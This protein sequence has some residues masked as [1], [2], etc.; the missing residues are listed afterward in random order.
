MRNLA[1]SQ[2]GTVTIV[3]A[4]PGDPDLMTVGGLRALQQADLVL[5]D[6]LVNAALLEEAPFAEQVYV[7]KAPGHH[8][9]T[10]AEINRALIEGA[11]QGKR[12]VR[13]KGGDPFVFGRG[14]EEC[15]ALALAGIPFKVIPGISSALAGPAYAG[16]PVTHRHVAT[17]FT[18]VTGHT[19]GAD[20]IDWDALPRRG[21]LVI[22]MGV[23]HLPQIA[24]QLV[25][26]GRAAHTPAAVIH[27]ATTDAQQMVTGT[28]ADIAER[29]HHLPAPA[30]IVVGEVVRLAAEIGWFEPQ[31]EP[32][33]SLDF[34]NLEPLAAAPAAY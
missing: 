3:G 1:I 13:L 18:V 34:L 10:Q 5:Y 26:H 30:V 4:G 25:A 21:T 9:Y 28:L 24:A 8:A 17:S 6:R 20:G 16:I 14:G 12:V 11:Q 19:A 15:Q 23:A 7:G 31:T 22:L 29:A 32:A 33:F 27:H 2:V